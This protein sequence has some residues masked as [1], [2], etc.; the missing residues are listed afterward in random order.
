LRQEPAPTGER[1]P[2]YGGAC[3]CRWQAGAREALA[4]IG[5]AARVIGTVGG[6]ALELEGELSVAVSQLARVHA[7]GLASM[8]GW[9]G[10]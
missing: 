6:E 5:A 9:A 7:N 4:A 1:Y 2:R 10:R 3:E 8:L